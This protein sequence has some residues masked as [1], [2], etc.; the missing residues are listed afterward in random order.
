M[1]RLSSYTLFKSPLNTLQ[2]AKLLINTINAHSW[3]MA[4]EDGEFNRALHQSDVLLP[5]GI[6]VVLALRWL[7][8]QKLK[9]IAG[10]DLFYY[11]MERMQKE[12]GTGTGT[13][14]GQGKGGRVFFLGSTEETLAKIKA[15][16][17]QEYPGVLVETYSPPY[18]PI[19]TD[20]EN[21]AMIKAINAFK[22]DVLFIGMTA[23][24]QEKWA[25]AHFEQLD[26]GHVCSIGAVFDFY[27]G[28]V[29]RAP[30]WAITIGMEWC[31]RLVKEPRRMWRRYL[32]GNCKFCWA[33]VREKLK[34]PQAPNGRYKKTD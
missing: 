13:G 34:A 14:T 18:K 30:R 2:P 22:P 17:A 6:S 4:R 12:T 29:K 27:A 25:A 10:E 16:A 21:A 20:E 19:F 24:K 11:E 5:D 33:V 1:S 3:N 7:T 26:A 31:Y 23:P 8:G 32:V 28:T 15:R 9:K